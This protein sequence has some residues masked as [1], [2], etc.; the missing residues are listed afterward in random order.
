MK[1]FPVR[2]KIALLSLV[3]VFTV[4]LI[5][6]GS[7]QAS[8]VGVF[9]T[10]TATDFCLPAPDQLSYRLSFKAS[11]TAVGTS[12]PSKVRIGFQVLDSDTKRVIRSGVVNL[13]RSKGYKA[14][15]PKFTGTADEKISY[16][17][18]MSYKSGGKTLKKKKSFPDQI[19]SVD[20]LA[21]S[22]LPAC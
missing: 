18:N 11:V 1:G 6:A 19:P 21:N 22:T 10:P 9:V 17:L 7:A 12:K 2:K 13:K 15:T 3:S 4:G 16:H 14:D 8:Y 5:A 20:Q